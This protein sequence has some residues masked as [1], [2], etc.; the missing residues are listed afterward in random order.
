MLPI[1]LPRK[2]LDSLLEDAIQR[3]LTTARRMA[4]LKIL[5]VERNLTRAQ[6]I[7]RVEYKLGKNC[8]GASAWEDTF[9]RDMRMVKQA[10]QSANYVLEYSRNK[11][12]KGYFLQGQPALSPELKKV[13]Q[14]SIA[15]VD[16]RQIDIYRKLSFAARFQQGCSISDTARKVVVYRIQQENPTLSLQEANQLALQRSYT[17]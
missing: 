5:W 3:D 8:F 9:Y 17:T 1:Q 7:K 16:T 12:Q 15:E 6:L 2:I 10:F 11:K 13:I 4:L 14:A